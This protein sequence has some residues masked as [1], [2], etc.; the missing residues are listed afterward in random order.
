MNYQMSWN[1]VHPNC[2]REWNR[3]SQFAKIFTSTA[4]I[5][6]VH[7]RQTRQRCNPQRGGK[8]TMRLPGAS[9]LDYQSSTTNISSLPI[10]NSLFG[11]FANQ[12]CSRL[13]KH[14]MPLNRVEEWILFI[15]LRGRFVLVI[16]QFFFGIENRIGNLLEHP[17]SPKELTFWYWEE[18]QVIW[19]R[20]C[21][22]RCLLDAMFRQDKWRMC[23]TFGRRHNTIPRQYCATSVVVGIGKMKS[24][25]RMIF[26]DSGV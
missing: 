20:C 10:T 8:G 11:V 26:Q 7:H 13:P 22:T 1:S 5:F 14:T 2:E 6:Y 15:Y 3:F 4:P 25:P 19:W 16:T 21:L 18:R 17:L 24:L 12:C 9:L 23:Q